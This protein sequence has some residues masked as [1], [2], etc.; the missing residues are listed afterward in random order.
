MQ[1][2][3]WWWYVAR[4]QIL[5]RAYRATLW[6]VVHRNADTHQLVWYLK[7]V[8]IC[9]RRGVAVA[10]AQHPDPCHDSRCLILC[11]TRKFNR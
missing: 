3:A 6:K 5:V 11:P 1:C 10:I 4:R 8:A 9:V 2:K 7:D